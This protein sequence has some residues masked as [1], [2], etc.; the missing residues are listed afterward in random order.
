[1]PIHNEDIA[2]H[3]EEIADLL[4]IRGDNPF[5]VRA[6]RNGAR[7]VRA[8]PRSA[9]ELLAEG[10]DLTRYP[11][12]GEA[13]ATKI[14]ELVRTGTT[15][16]MEKLRREIP[17]SLEEL[18]RIPGLGPVRIRT[19]WHE[20]GITD[21]DGL[22][23]AARD[24]RLRD[25]PGFGPKTE[26]KV[27]TAIEEHRKKKRR[28]LRAVAADYGEPL[29]AWLRGG[30]G[31]REVV[32]AGSYRRGRD[33][34][35]DLD[36]LTVAPDHSDVMRRFTRYEEVAKVVSQGPTRA[37]VVLRCGLQVD[38]RRVREESFGSALQYFTGSK[39]HSIQLRRLAQD[40]GLKINE[41]GVFRDERRVAGRTEESVYASVGL[42]WIPPELREARGEIDAAAQGRLP[43]LVEPSDIRGE[44]HC[45]TNATDGRASLEEMARA[46]QARGLEYLAITDHS[47]RLTMVG[48]LGPEA[49]RR[50]IEAI[51]RLNERLDGLTLLK[52]IE[53]DILEDGSLDL[54]D[55]VL[56]ELDLVV[57][58]V[59]GKF[60]LPRAKQTDRIL[61]A[62]DHRYFTLLAHPTGR[63][64]QQRPPYD[65]DLD[66]VIAHAAQRGC[67]LELNSQP[68]R[69]DLDDL[70]CMKAREAGVLV[71]IDTDAHSPA[72]LDLR[73][74]GIA[75]ARRGWLEA[76]DVLNA[77]PL[78]ELRPL[79]ARTMG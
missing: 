21:L 76:A 78:A 31:V 7:A 52:G 12:I 37:T 40:Q 62:M 54:P 39:A 9:A 79:L 69:L 34:V 29:A 30:R 11:D 8:L 6:Y 3:F 55:D 65:V 72:D 46:A 18:L 13:L 56:A 2:A 24:G 71:A 43:K 58:A 50:Q 27:L 5:R 64:I 20:L 75:Q 61:R 57:G 10:E 45:H 51:D 33:T 70:A 23:A 41:Y 15:Q 67:Y 17:P 60:D 16:A 38:L 4:E 48:G 68:L 42:P 32:I 26:Q 22:E 63:L 49:L 19:L 36:I 25:L 59:H 73:V 77:R 44:L 66:R 74:H 47:Q 28:F 14:A 1:M 53:C 35:G